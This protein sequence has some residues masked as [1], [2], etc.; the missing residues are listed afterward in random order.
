MRKFST[1]LTLIFV[2][3]LLGAQCSMS[4]TS[5]L[6]LESEDKTGDIC[7]YT[8][9]GVF[10]ASASM[11]DA[12]TSTA[13]VVDIVDATEESFSATINPDLTVDF[14]LTIT[15]TCGESFL[16]TLLL[17]D[18]DGNA[19]KAESPKISTQIV[20]PVIWKSFSGKLISNR[21]ELEWEVEEDGKNAG[22]HIEKSFDGRKFESIDFVKSKNEQSRFSKY[23]YIDYSEKNREGYIYY[24]LKQI[25]VN[26]QFSYSRIV[27]MDEKLSTDNIVISPNPSYGSSTIRFTSVS[28]EDMSVSVLDQFGN[29]VYQQTSRLF[30]GNNQMNL[31]LSNYPT[32]M[33][34]VQLSGKN[35]T[36][37][38]KLNKL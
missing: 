27:T 26:G 12:A 10:D 6:P 34:Y 36:Q 17:E 5:D 28:E 30:I 35:V 21:V 38:L 25:D 16:F 32:G 37:V 14:S 19:C 29:V 8:V 3:L 18:P 22:F 13:S 23:S 11:A 20:L 31:D 9:E 4:I 2:P 15:T 1:F 33:Y 24:R 7:T